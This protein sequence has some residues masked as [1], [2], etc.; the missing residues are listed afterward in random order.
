MS[1]HPLHR[2]ILA[3]ILALSL[4]ALT[5]T[6]SPRTL[7]LDPDILVSSTYAVI[8]TNAPIEKEVVILP[9]RPWEQLMIS[10]FFTVRDE[11]G[12]LRLWYIC[13]D[14][15]NQPN[16]AYAESTD[17]IHWI[18]PNLGIV[19]YHGSTD[20]NLVGIPNL[21]GVVFRDETAPA[22]ERYV[23]ITNVYH[24]GIMR[25]YSPDGLRW[26]KSTDILLSFEADTQLV[27]FRDERLGKYVTYLR[28]WD[29]G[30]DTERQRKVVR[31]EFD[32]YLGHL[33]IE[34]SG[35]PTHPASAAKTRLHWIVD[36]IPTVL[37]TDGRDP[38]H[39]DIYNISAQPY[40]VDPAWY[41][42]F[43][44]FYRH[45]PE[46]DDPPY[47]N[48]GRTEIQFVGSRDGINWQRYD[49]Q[50]YIA[51]SLVGADR[52]NM[53]FMGTGLV[54]RGDEIW[55]FATGFHS[56]HG[57][58]AARRAKTDGRIVRYVQ[59]VDGFV[60][61]N[62]GDTT[63][64]AQTVP[65]DISGNT[66]RLNLDTGGLGS[67]RVGLVDKDGHEVPGFGV[68]NCVPLSVNDTGAQVQWNGGAD[69]SNLAHRQLSLRFESNRTRL[70]SFRFE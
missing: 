68:A 67:L 33:A 45:D 7:F 61:L 52:G 35:V 49:R 42:G 24:E 18:K 32:S 62:T 3:A 34:P 65:V 57:D 26:T 8:E 48:S 4:S 23:Y 46:S 60:S 69:L 36:E 31:L 53:V 22:A 41:V 44:S 27:T 58:V 56:R 9:D 16:V 13:R 21:E 20:N 70:F 12:T 29:P 66:L 1:P 14:L 40:P 47:Q 50:P 55:H 37:A 19:D 30:S 39:T 38:A 28:G 63:G 17:G 15:D 11:G 51:P 10:F 5:A 59:R 2:P 6:A 54:I 43:P 64:T 25:F